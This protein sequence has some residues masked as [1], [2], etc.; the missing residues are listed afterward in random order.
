MIIFVPYSGRFW[1]YLIFLV[2]G[3]CISCLHKNIE[4]WSPQILICSILAFL[5]L[6]PYFKGNYY[7]YF[8]NFI[9]FSPTT[10][11]NISLRDLIIVYKLLVASFGCIAL[12][13]LFY[14]LYG[15]DKYSSYCKKIVEKISQN[16]LGIY[17]LQSLFIERL[18]PIFVNL[19]EVLDLNN[20][21]ELFLYTNIVSSFV[22]IAGAVLCT[23]F[24]EFLSKNKCLGFL[25]FAK[26]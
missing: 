14:E 22:G 13:F 18:L 15:V 16:T 21:I 25:F 3:F 10:Y 23:L 19:H 9:K 6:V 7:I 1:F 24:I 26:K 17:I 12:F 8:S 2:E 11:L 20:Q 5:F 4:K